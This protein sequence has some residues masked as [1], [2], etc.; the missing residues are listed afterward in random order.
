MTTQIMGHGFGSD[1]F[2]GGSSSCFISGSGESLG[3]RVS[4]FV[5]RWILG[6]KRSIPPFCRV[7]RN[8]ELATSSP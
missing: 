8:S 2:P 7:A 1:F 6:R 3:I 5:C 4:R